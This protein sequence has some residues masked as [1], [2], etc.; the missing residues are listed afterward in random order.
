MI[1]HMNNDLL[2]EIRSSC[3]A[4]AEQATSVF[5]NHDKI[6]QY[7]AWLPVDETTRFTPDPTCHYLGHG[8]D[9]VAFFL[10]LDTINF[11]SG[12]FPYIRKR[13]GMSGYFTI[14]SFLNDHFKNYGPFTAR[15][16]AE[17][18]PEQCVHIFHQEDTERLATELMNLF[19]SALREFGVFLIDRFNGSFAGLVES[20]GQS[21]ERL[22]QILSELDFYN[23]TASYRGINVMF[24]KRAQIAAADLFLAFKGKGPG[25]F[26]DIGLLT[27]FA[28]NLVP[29][30][31]RL[32]GILGYDDGLL[33]CIENEEEI[34]AASTEEVEIRACTVHA[35]ELLAEEMNRLGKRVNS[36]MIDQF[37]WNRGQLP[38]FKSHPRHRTR[39][40]F[41]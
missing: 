27:I 12:Y 7:A 29:H 18:T 4:V 41:Y 39:T 35:V 32:D 5:I 13:N 22:V 40:V 6:R 30:V 17:I 26:N 31:L 28:D 11:G 16:L 9:T 24:F 23:D 3:K 33:S 37:L 10:T 38:Q 19:A 15:E 14:A 34:P 2:H 20:A 8:D 36:M 21:A 25:K 1:S